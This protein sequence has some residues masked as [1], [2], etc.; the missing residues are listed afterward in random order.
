MCWL[1]GQLKVLPS[2]GNKAG[3][4]DFMAGNIHDSKGALI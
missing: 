4:D 3:I 2:E 1:V